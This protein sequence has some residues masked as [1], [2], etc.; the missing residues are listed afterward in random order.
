MKF[1]KQL[2]RG[3]RERDVTALAD[4]LSRLTRNAQ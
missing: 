2:R 4:V 3:L 1:D